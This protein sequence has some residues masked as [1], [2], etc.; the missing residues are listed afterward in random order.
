M[1]SHFLVKVFIANTINVNVL[2]L[3]RILM[4][5]DVFWLV[6]QPLGSSF[7]ETPPWKHFLASVRHTEAK[8]Q[9]SRH[10]HQGGPKPYKLMTDMNKYALS[11]LTTSLRRRTAAIKG[12]FYTV[13]KFCLLYTSDAADE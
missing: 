5:R 4:V 6:E 10:G 7:F 12:K 3:V 13:G 2:M 9:M 11:M 8:G 1:P